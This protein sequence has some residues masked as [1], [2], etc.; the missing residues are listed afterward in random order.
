ME[1]TA[2]IDGLAGLRLTSPPVALRGCLRSRFRLSFALWSRLVL[3]SLGALRR[4]ARLLE[5]PSSPCR[6]VL[7]LEG[8]PPFTASRRLI[9]LTESI[10][11]LS[12]SSSLSCSAV[13]LGKCSSGRTLSPGLY[14]ASISACSACGFAFSGCATSTMSN[15]EATVELCLVS[16]TE[17]RHDGHVKTEEPGTGGSGALVAA[18]ACQSN[19]S[20]R[21]APQKVCRQSR[22]VRGLYRSSVQI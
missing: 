10:R 6:R 15:S 8:P 12:R 17:A 4:A 9:S 21:Q 7:E 20:F 14:L 11:C 1:S 13:R 3:V 18:F 5:P 2:S 19:H 22:R 16:R